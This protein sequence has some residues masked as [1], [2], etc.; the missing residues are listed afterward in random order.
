M[1]E[2]I[3]IM[4]DAELVKLVASHADVLTV[5]IEYQMRG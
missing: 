2:K 4:P 3:T 1:E 5:A